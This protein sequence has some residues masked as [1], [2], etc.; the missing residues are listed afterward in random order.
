MNF[1]K[2]NP[3]GSRSNKISVRG[4]RNKIDCGF[5]ATGF[6]TVAS[7]P[8]VNDPFKYVSPFLRARRK[9]IDHYSRISWRVSVSASHN[10]YDSRVICSL[11]VRRRNIAVRLLLTR[12][13]NPFEVP[14]AN[15]KRICV[16]YLGIEYRA[17]IFRSQ[18]LLF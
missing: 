17:A 18:P 13:E 14:L 1:Q 11:I 16:I 7:M 12:S 8:K 6:A 10:A 9:M 2:E 3:Q 15:L 4:M 5:C